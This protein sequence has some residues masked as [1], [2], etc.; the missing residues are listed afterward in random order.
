MLN[1]LVSGI[2][3]ERLH[4]VSLVASSDFTTPTTNTDGRFNVAGWQ[5]GRGRIPPSPGV[6]LPPHAH[7][8]LGARSGRLRLAVHSDA[9][10]EKGYRFYASRNAAQQAFMDA[11]QVSTWC[12]RT[13][14]IGLCH[15]RRQRPNGSGWKRARDARACESDVS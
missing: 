3:W 13:R 8:R 1:R 10:R 9:G 11:E 14:E 4:G 15:A 12:T 2:E 5:C 6:V 7:E